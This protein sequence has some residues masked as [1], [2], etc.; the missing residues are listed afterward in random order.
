MISALMLLVLNG[1]TERTIIKLKGDM[2][3]QACKKLDEM[4]RIYNK[5]KIEREE[6]NNPNSLIEGAHC[7]ACKNGYENYYRDEY[8]CELLI[9]CKKYDKKTQSP[10]NK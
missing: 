3:D 6:I 9:K 2:L 7:G 1:S 10:E 4:N 8:S 5:T